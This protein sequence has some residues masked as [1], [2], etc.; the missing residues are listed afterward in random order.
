MNTGHK[1]I[2]EEDAA[3]LQMDWPEFDARVNENADVPISWD[4][5]RQRRGYLQRQRNLQ[6]AVQEAVVRP[7]G[8]ATFGPDN[9]IGLTIGYFDIETT[10]STQPR[11]LY[12]AVADAWGNVYGFDRNE[13][14]GADKWVDDLALINAYVD[15]LEE[16]DIVVSWNGKLFDVPVLNARFATN[17]SKRRYAPEHHIDLMYQAGMGKMRIGRRSLEHVS[18]VFDSPNR[19]TPLDVRTWDT[20]TS[21][22]WESEEAYDR[23]KEHCDADVLVLRDV[24]ND[25]KPGLRSIGR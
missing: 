22:S 10:F 8:P 7:D 1:W 5:W 3:A 13:Y 19:K 12:A 25:L 4:A 16:F 2:A 11:V 21:G 9:F 23:I 18:D 15:K 6:N 17:K 24:F 20:A 14:P